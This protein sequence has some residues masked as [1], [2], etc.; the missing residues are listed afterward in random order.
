[1]A[2]LSLLRFRSPSPCLLLLPLPSPLLAPLPL[3]IPNPE[4]GLRSCLRASSAG[5]SSTPTLMRRV[6]TAGLPVFVVTL[7]APLLWASEPSDGRLGLGG[8]VFVAISTVVGF[9]C[10]SHYPPIEPRDSMIDRCLQASGSPRTHES[11]VSQPLLTHVSSVLACSQC[12]RMLRAV[13]KMFPS[14]NM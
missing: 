1:M 3:A 6:V 9:W 7:T 4:W 11:R 10:V 14:V 8:W 12:P 13:N 2:G 5:A